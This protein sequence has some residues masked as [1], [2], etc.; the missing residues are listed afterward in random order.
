M[1]VPFAQ[2]ETDQFTSICTLLSILAVPGYAGPG[3]AIPGR[4]MLASINPDEYTQIDI[5]GHIDEAIPI[6]QIGAQI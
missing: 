3:C 5:T 6:G 4:P 1:T 2:L